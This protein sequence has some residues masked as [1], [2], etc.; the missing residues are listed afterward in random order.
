M[1]RLYRWMTVVLS[2]GLL[3]ACATGTRLESVDMAT[4]SNAPYRKVL[5]LAI[6]DNGQIRQ[7]VE[8]GL[9]GQLHSHGV[10]HV[11]A[12]TLM[13]GGLD[14]EQPESIRARAEKVVRDTGVD[15]VLVAMLLHE[16]VRQEY[17]PP[18]EESVPVANVPYF[19]GYGAYVGFHYQTV[20]T[21]GYYREEQNYY[22][23][24]TLFDVSNEQQV[25]RA[26]SR[27]VNP[28]NIQDGV[29]SLSR[30]VVN[31]LLKD[32]MLEAD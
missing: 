19:M 24:N 6:S 15:A 18:R 22:V 23:Q 30:L 26:Q 8:Q 25:W 7:V 31:R 29:A 14:K 10:E 21:P 9:A 28:V 20:Y 5:V 12:S 32:G 11:V 16:E 1:T 3:V 13:P 27:T 2:A 4:D 17:V